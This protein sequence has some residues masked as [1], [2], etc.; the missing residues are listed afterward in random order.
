MERPWCLQTYGYTPAAPVLLI[1]PN[2]MVARSRIG[3]RI[4]THMAGIF[5]LV[6][7]VVLLTALGLLGLAWLLDHRRRTGKP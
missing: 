6:L 1:T 4:W 2:G 5:V 7:I 3:S